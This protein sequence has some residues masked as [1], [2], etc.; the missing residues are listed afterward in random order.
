MIF[1][2]QFETE[3]AVVS[4]LV[5][6]AV[7]GD[8]TAMVLHHILSVADAAWLVTRN[9]HIAT[10]IERVQGLHNTARESHSATDAKRALQSS[11][12][13]ISFTGVDRPS[14]SDRKINRTSRCRR[15]GGSLICARSTKS[16]GAQRRLGPVDTWRDGHLAGRSRKVSQSSGRGV[17]PAG[18]QRRRVHG[19]LTT[20]LVIGTSEACLQ[21]P[22]SCW[23]VGY[24]PATPQFYA[25]THSCSRLRQKQYKYAFITQLGSRVGYKCIRMLYHIFLKLTATKISFILNQSNCF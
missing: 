13:I 14:V 22:T 10:S 17:W 20:R 15:S 21:T 25:L 19:R 7:N 2:F 6:V 1:K 12:Y 11:Q 8:A 24:A 23:Y 4:F 9:D 16:V 18:Q 3:L 5:A